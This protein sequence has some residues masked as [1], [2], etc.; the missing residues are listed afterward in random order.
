L[1]DDPS[2]VYA[3]EKYTVSGD[4]R[5]FRAEVEGLRATSSSSVR[6]V[7]TQEIDALRSRCIRTTYISEVCFVDKAA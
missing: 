1:P 7:L 6:V 2:L 5:S 3:Y 4:V